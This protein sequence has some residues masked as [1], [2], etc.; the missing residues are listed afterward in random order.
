MLNRYIGNKNV[1]LPSLMDTI[2]KHAK[3]GDLVCDAFSGSVA[4]SFELK[5]K[6]YRVACNDVNLFSHFYGKHLIEQCTLPDLN[7]SDFIDQK[8]SVKYSGL[9]Q[10]WVK[11]LS[12]NQEGYTFLK[13]K[14]YH[15]SYTNLLTLVL[16]LQSVESSKIDK[17]FRN[18]F[19]FNT[20]TEEGKNSA[21]ISSRGTKGNRKFFT[22]QNGIQIDN[23]LNKIREWRVSGLLSEGY[24]YYTL[25]CVLIDA[26]EKVSNTQGT[27]HD[28]PR[29]SYDSRA[30]QKL[31]LRAPAYDGII[32]KRL[33]HIIGNEEDSLSF[34][35]RVPKHSALY[36][37]P[38]YNFRQY[39]S[40]YFLPNILCKYS[41]IEDLSLYFSEVEFV[42]GQNMNDNFDSS[43]CKK[44]MFLNSLRSLISDAKCKTV[45]LSYF[46]GRNHWNNTTEASDKEGFDVLT[47]LFNEEIFNKEYS[48]YLPIERLNYQSYG[49]HKAQVV[50]EFLFF[51]DKK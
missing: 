18:S 22:P 11:D 37:D 21:F 43:F 35:K 9:A 20:Y 36:L 46:D 49:G 8:S 27:Y 5:K 38:P 12:N 24:L 41:D 34:I 30:L 31:R 17:K 39:T 26:V 32:S 1:I 3:P 44:G 6:G 19:I 14:K 16:F 51:G 23:I 50:N 28:F 47:Q 45:L 42:R 10:E 7:L 33:S 15:D 4:V 13:N 48:S 2:S 40:Y 25:I 29:D